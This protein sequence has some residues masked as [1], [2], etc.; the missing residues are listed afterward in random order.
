MDHLYCRSGSRPSASAEPD[1]KIVGTVSG[2]RGS[3]SLH[4]PHRRQ[5]SQEE[6][7]RRNQE[8]FARQFQQ[9]HRAAMA[10]PR[11]PMGLPPGI[12]LSFVQTRAL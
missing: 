1:I 12:I 3:P 8:N 7:I 5:E 2:S 6:L 4:H 9:S 10:D 11:H